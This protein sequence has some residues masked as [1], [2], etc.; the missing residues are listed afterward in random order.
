MPIVSDVTEGDFILRMIG[1]E[2]LWLE[3]YSSI[4]EYTDTDIIVVS[5]HN[6]IHIC[7]VRLRIEYYGMVEMKVT[8]CIEKIQIL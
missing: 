4:T 1:K 2:K 7:G 8:G 6:Q 5:R 3:N